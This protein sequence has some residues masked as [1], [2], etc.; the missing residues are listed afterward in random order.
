[1]AGARQH[2]RARSGKPLRVELGERS[3]PIHIGTGTLAQAGAEIAR[4][5]QASR[6]AIVTVAEVGRRYAAAL[7]KG[8]RS[9]GIKV[10]RFDVPDGDRTKNLR[11]AARL[12]SAFLDKGLDRSSAAIALGGGVVGDLTG[13]VAATYLR[14]ISFVQV[15]TTLLSMV[16][17]SVGGKV[18]VNLPEGKNLVG[19]F[20]QPKLV[21]IDAATLRTLPERQRVA[22]M[23]EVI[24]HAAIWDEG[25]FS[26]LEST[27]EAIL[28]LDPEQI[29]PL[30]RR[31][32]AIKA[33][34]VAR[35]ERESGVRMLLNFGHTMGHAVET[36]GRYRK[37][38]HGEAVGIGMV[39]AAQRSEDLGLAPAGTRQRLE[40][41]VSRV[42]LPTLMPGFPRRAYLSALRVDKKKTDARIRFVALRAIGRAEIV[43]LTPGEIFPP[44]RGRTATTKRV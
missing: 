4:R 18:G 34:V 11:E 21:W 25:L 40:A 3:Y 8:L 12:Y 32:C 27:A 30:I 9:E 2:K 1:M 39:Y 17:A 37:I 44:R 29:E 33:E 26:D 19:A 36:L 20:Y 5:T 28:A 43:P 41:L 10:H 22:G 16:D 14:G 31:N 35:D 6:V 7:S 23:G 38:L 42:G 15:P 24:K 13:F